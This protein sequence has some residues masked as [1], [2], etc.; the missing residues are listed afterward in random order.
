MRLLT[1]F[2]ISALMAG[3]HSKQSS[4]SLE[5]S[6]ASAKELFDQTSTNFHL[7]SAEAKGAE[8]TRLQERAI[9]GYTQLLKKYP[10]D[11]IYAAQAERNLGNILAGQGR[12]DDAIQRFEAVG[13]KYPN[14]A[15]EVLMA[16]KS[17]GDLLWENGRKEE[18]KEFY[19]RII[20]R[21][22]RPEAPAV[23]KT[24]VKGS[25]LRLAGKDLSAEN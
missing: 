7:P 1:L 25:K 21:Y 23:T 14:Q 15:W 10:N 20:S 5:D 9:S 6:N 22:D 13:K 3:C 24:I 11:P 4:L 17:A 8:Q 2:L 12:V 16:W 19:Q 18:G